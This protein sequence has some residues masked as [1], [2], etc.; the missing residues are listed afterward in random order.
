MAAPAT[1]ATRQ[2]AVVY[3]PV[4]V[5]GERLRH[6]VAAA[7]SR[8]GWRKSLWMET[9]EADPGRGQARRAVA[10]GVDVVLAAG[11]DGTVRSVAE[12]L[13][14]SE[15]A[16]ALLPAGTG[17]LLARNLD[18]GLTH[19]DAA[20]TTAFEGRDRRIDVGVV[21]LERPDGATEEHAFLV[22][23]GF[24]L[25]AKMIANARPELKRRVGW[26][27]YVDA[28]ARSLRDTSKAKLRATL[29][30]GEE[31][32]TSVHTMIVGNAGALPGNVLLLPEAE[33]DDGIFDIVTLRPEGLG[34]WVQI[35]AKITW[36]NGILRRSSVGRKL[37]GLSREV[38]T[39]RYLRAER[40]T[41]QLEK[42]QEF[43]V[44]GDPLG[45]VVGFRARVDPRSLT[46]R[47]PA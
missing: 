7:E 33:I 25:D 35:W 13:R 2:A 8:E 20:V 30:D 3:N 21:E 24:G 44:D 27:A 9:T 41:V 18:I 10:E 46:V 14:G 22:M 36:E 34:G 5:D 42:P 32:S 26:L 1:R 19:L 37:A 38:R 31:R 47:V 11:G 12:G 39:L 6:A 28:I 15:V 45:M 29:D 17:N 43:E 4:K 16:L 40:L 23:A